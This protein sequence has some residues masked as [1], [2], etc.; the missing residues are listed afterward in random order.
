MIAKSDVTGF[1]NGRPFRFA[2]G[3]EVEAPDAL[4]RALREQGLVMAKPR[5]KA[6]EKKG[7]SDD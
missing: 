5:R 1:H 4:V 2:R 6:A 7:E 3:A